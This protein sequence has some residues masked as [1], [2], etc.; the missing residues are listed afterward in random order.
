MRR[1]VLVAGLALIAA[2]VFAT[3]AAAV[4][5]N[6]R[7]VGQQDRH[8]VAIFDAPHAD[9]ATIYLATKPDRAT[10]GRF[11]EE[12]IKELDLLTDSEIQSGRWVDESQLDPGNYWVLLR[13]SP[14]FE[15][16]YIYDTG[17][18]DPA[19]A[20]GFSNVLT[21]SIPVPAT[22]YRAGVTV[23]RGLGEVSLRLTA[24][25]LG[26][27]RP[28]R[29][30]YRLRTGRSRCVH[31]TLDGYDWNSSADDTL[32]VSTRS[33]PTI[34]TFS[35]Y[36]TAGPGSLGPAKRVATKRVRVR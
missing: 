7:A 12:N 17:G 19:C 9:F 3:P 28:Y 26:E 33:L 6:L 24:S 21:L 15:A 32:S 5:P 35:W 34:V 4:S 11:L 23:Y 18:F 29:V 25:P 13:A 10:D 20:D 27:K 2:L 8:P 16:C 36:V 14:D 1:R 30:C 31:G 22:R